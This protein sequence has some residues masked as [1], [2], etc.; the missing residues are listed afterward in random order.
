MDIIIRQ[1]VPEDLDAVARVEA[2]CFPEAEAASRASFAQR[3][4][5]FPESFF[6]AERMGRIVGFINGCVTDS[7]VIRDEMFEDAGLHNP[8]GAYQSIFGLDVIPE[9]RRRGLAARLMN[10]LIAETKKRGK[11]GLILTC[12]DRLIGYYER[13][14]YRNLGVSQSVHGGAI[15]YDMILEWEDGCPDYDKRQEKEQI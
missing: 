5:A 13:F 12:K 14:G 4:E 3:I 1:V 7:R 11:K 8:E 9:L 10:H 6:V 2:V 15:W